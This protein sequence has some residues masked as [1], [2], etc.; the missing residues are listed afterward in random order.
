MNFKKLLEDRYSV[1]EYLPQ[2]IDKEIIDYIIEC[3]RLA[4]SACNKQ[5][6][7]FY[8]VTSEEGRKAVAESYPRDWFKEA[9]LNILICAD[10]DQSWKRS[11]DNKDHCDVDA[12]ITATYMCLAAESRQLGVCW[13]CNFNPQL[14]K[15]NLNLTENIEPV[16]ILSIGYINEVKTKVPQKSRKP[17]DDFVKWL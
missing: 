10:H 2:E 4:P 9:P 6:W 16:T 11:S 13:I 14:L 7:Q 3:G 1:R 8:V 15:A 17:V 5:P 12:A